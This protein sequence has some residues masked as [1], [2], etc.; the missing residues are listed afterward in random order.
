M[1]IMSDPFFIDVEYGVGP[2][3]LDGGLVGVAE[4]FVGGLEAAE[5]TDGALGVPSILSEAEWVNNHRVS[6]PF[7]NPL[8]SYSS[9]TDLICSMTML[10]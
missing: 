10:R 7:L 6:G 1:S 8:S 4:E 2:L 3:H 9:R 5:D